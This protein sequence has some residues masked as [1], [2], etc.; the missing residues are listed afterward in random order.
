MPLGLGDFEEAL[1]PMYSLGGTLNPVIV[2][3]STIRD[4]IRFYGFRHYHSQQCG[5]QDLAVKFVFCAAWLPSIQSA[6]L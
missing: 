3:I 2:T 4:N 6:N 1:G 5:F